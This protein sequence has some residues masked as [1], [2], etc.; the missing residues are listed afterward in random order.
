MVKIRVIRGGCGIEYRDEHGNVR[1]MLK[2]SEDGPFDCDSEAAARLV[3][4]EV[5]EYV[6]KQITP[7]EGG[8]PE[9]RNLII[10]RLPDGDSLDEEG[11]LREDEIEEIQLRTMKIKDLDLLARNRGLDTSQC[12]KKDDYIG[13]LLEEVQEEEEELPVLGGADPV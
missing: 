13:L 10:G 11:E 3:S 2:T 7:N 8:V 4:L 1:H 9:E 5:A 12:K 6:G